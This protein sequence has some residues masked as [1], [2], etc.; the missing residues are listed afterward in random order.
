MPVAPVVLAALAALWAHLYWSLSPVW[1]EG[2][3]YD[4]GWLVPPM[5]A[6]FFW[7]R[8]KRLPAEGAAPAGGGMGTLLAVAAAVV[9]SFPAIRALNLVDANWRPPLLLQAMVVTAAT[10]LLLGRFLGWRTSLIFLPVTIYALTAVPYPWQ[11]EQAMV[12]ELTGL[13]IA[14]TT[15][16]FNLWGRPVEMIGEN[17]RLDQVTVS[18]SDAC[19]GIRSIQST[20]MASLFLGELYLLR[21]WPRALLVVAGAVLAVV[22]NIG[23][24]ISLAVIRFDHGAEAF[25]KQHDFVGHVAFLVAMV[26]L[27]LLAMLLHHRRLYEGKRV[28]VRRK[29]GE[30]PRKGGLS[31]PPSAT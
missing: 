21:L 19:S 14:I 20:L 1:R 25:E 8:W 22:T 5:A 17:L 26:L 30:G 18:V 12:R 3:Y 28:V 16:L 7:R 9:L 4:Y 6:F 23:R 27:L 10:H 31:N 29:E 11:I 24:A 13:V 2:G 15:E